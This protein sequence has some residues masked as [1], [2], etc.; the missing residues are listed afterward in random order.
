MSFDTIEP[1][2]PEKNRSVL[3]ILIGF[4]ICFTLFV[5]VLN[6]ESL[7]YKEMVTVAGISYT[8][9]DM[10]RVQVANDPLFEDIIYDKINVS[11]TWLLECSI[12]DKYG[13]INSDIKFWEDLIYENRTAWGK[14]HWKDTGIINYRWSLFRQVGIKQSEAK[15]YSRVMAYV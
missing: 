7:K 2:E 6:Q 9:D 10:F 8:K 14:L 15:I 1:I 3:Y 13:Y 11:Y 5:T 4:L 12:L